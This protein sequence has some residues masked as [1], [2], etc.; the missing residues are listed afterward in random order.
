MQHLLVTLA[1][2]ANLSSFK[3]SLL[4]MKEVEG[5]EF[6]STEHEPNWKSRLHR[7]G[8]PLT[9]AQREQFVDDMDNEPD[10]GISMEKMTA[11]LNEHF[12]SKWGANLL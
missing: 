1:D 12:Q 3:S 6:V 9:D 2:S 7:P 8:P 5:V 11:K 4:A 10:D